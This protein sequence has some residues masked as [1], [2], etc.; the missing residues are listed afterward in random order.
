MILRHVK[1]EIQRL[2]PSAKRAFWA[3]FDSPEWLGGSR[4][5]GMVQSGWEGPEWLG[6]S[7]VA[8]RVQSGWE[9]PEWLGWSRVA[10]TVQ[11]GWEG[12]E[13][14]GGSRV[15]GLVQSGWDGPEWLGR[16]RV[17]GRVQ[18]GWAGPEWLGRSRVAGTVFRLSVKVL[19]SP[20]SLK[21]LHPVCYP[22]FIRR[23]LQI[24]KSKKLLLY[25][26]VRGAFIVMLDT[27]HPVLELPAG[28]TH[29]G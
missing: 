14:L 10:G 19:H 16:S 7:R 22:R 5:A 21:F 18:S 4:I 17:A 1:G 9:G 26:L 20:I 12:P 3:L 27:E 24:K 6:W 13:W 28:H 8:G 2:T 15:A 29:R 23:C 25:G 11:S